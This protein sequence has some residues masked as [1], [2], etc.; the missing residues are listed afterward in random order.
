[1]LENKDEKFS[2][3]IE[4]A[5][6]L[7]ELSPAAVF[8]ADADGF[9]HL[10]NRTARKFFDSEDAGF[11]GKNILDFIHPESEKTIHDFIGKIPSG[12][13][14]KA[15]LKFI[16][17]DGVKIWGEISAKILPDGRWQAC[18][19]DISEKKQVEEQLRISEER[20]QIITGTAWDAIICMDE[21]SR[22]VFVNEAAERIFGYKTTDLVG[23]SITSIIPPELRE[24]HLRGFSEYLK[25]GSR[26]LNWNG[27]QLP[28]LRADGEIFPVE[29]SLAEYKQDGKHFFIGIARDI[30]DRK[31]TE[32]Q[33]AHLAAIVEDSDDAIISKDLNGIITSWNR[34][35]ENLFGYKADEV[36]GQSITILIPEKYLDE[37]PVIIG[38]IKRGEKIEHYETIRRRKNGELIQIS[39]T[40][41]P[42]KDKN[43]T[44]IGASK[45]A[46][47]ITEKKRTENELRESQMML[48]LAMQSSRMGV[49]EYEIEND[50]VQWSPELEEIFG[51]ERGEFKQNRTAFY[52][53]IHEDDRERMFYEV[54]SAIEEKRDYTVEFRFLHKDGS[55]RW[56]EG[57]GQAIYSKDGAPI[58]LYGSGLD[59]TERKLAEEKLRESEEKFRTMADNISQF[60]WMADDEGWIF[61]YNK[62]W[63][64]YTGTTLEEMQGWGW[65]KVHHPDEVERVKKKFKRHIESG[66]PWEDTFPLRSKEG[67]YRWFLS[68]ALP[69]RDESGKVLRWFGTNTDITDRKESEKALVAAERKAAEDYQ[70]LLARIV[71]LAQ[72]IGAAR[73]LNSIYRAVRDFVRH[74]MPCSGFFVSFFDAETNLKTAAYVWS[75][76]GEVDISKLPPL[77]LTPEGGPNSQAVFQKKSVVVN[78]YMDFM[79]DRPHV[80][81]QE[82]GIDPNSS[83]VI[84]MLVMT[85]VVGTLE[86]QAYENRAFNEEHKIA[87]EM[88]ANLAAVAIENVRLLQIEANARETAEA[89]NRAKDEFLSVLSHELRTPLNAILGWM[90][91][92]RSGELNEAK[93]ERALE[94]I[95][96]NARLQCNLIEDLLDVSRI[97]SGKMRIEEH[98]VDL[99]SVVK[100]S[101]DSVK[102]LAEAKQIAL[103]YDSS[104]DSL[105]IKG[106]QNRLQQIIINLA[107]NAIKFTSAGGSVILDLTT[108]EQSA[109]LEVTD[110]GVG[111]K[112]EFLSQIFDR[113]IQADSTTQRNYSGLGLGLTIAKHLTELHGGKISA[114]SGGENRGAK[115]TVEFPLFVEQNFQ[116]GFSAAKNNP[117]LIKFEK[118]FLKSKMIVL[119]D[120]DCDGI[121]P[122]QILLENH[123]ANVQ[124]F[125]S[126]AAALKYLTENK[127]DLLISDI[128]MPEVDGYQL[129]K[130][131]KDL[132]GNNSIPSIAL[133]AYAGAE[134]RHRAIEAG[135]SYH[136][137][138]PVDYDL[139]I[140]TVRK[141]LE[142]E[143]N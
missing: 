107:N 52:E 75:D 78:R 37:E 140:N 39:L 3:N 130:K 120:D 66:E 17:K 81:L 13:E 9:F 47:D 82:D 63:F 25:T 29:L 136:L 141:A 19:N 122:L 38:K 60:A 95:E 26:K 30:T 14:Q 2:A 23:Q 64:E 79:Q 98:E 70:A 111:I 28:A 77:E 137:P 88:V 24:K 15:A 35:A 90:K 4:L 8:I 94:T 6:Q 45:I 68:R 110:T 121:E 21:N 133:T 58:R 93:T 112:P 76:K 83:L 32:K 46:R 71:P 99:V 101:Y 57:R 11:E 139:F 50:I 85:R 22:I 91:M 5:R 103:K 59:I 49:W 20:Y 97:I 12:I 86:V 84:P 106:D 10:V 138:K 92:L 72:I 55:V 27:L 62:R 117:A 34:G 44:I 143:K 80:I 48:A 36:I 135:F 124:C 42:I 43:G 41:S 131:V 1:M 100:S 51:L 67:E 87:L 108:T 7:T 125:D 114:S 104:V 56:M 69:I 119:V 123:G 40:V 105:I 134:D 118:S 61:W 127:S 65:E 73:D 109:R 31:K 115:F 142:S 18:L 126:A 96:R 74:S 54:E 129:I 16:R 53:L 116:S 102:P 132:N 89:A 113:F 33:T 128:G